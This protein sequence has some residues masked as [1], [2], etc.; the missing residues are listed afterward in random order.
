[1]IKSGIFPVV[2]AFCFFLMIPLSEAGTDDAP[3][4]WSIGA[5]IGP[6]FYTQDAAVLVANQL[7]GKIG[8]I[9]NG[10]FLYKMNRYLGA[11]F[12]L[13]W[14]K[15]NLDSATQ[16]WGEASTFSV[17]LLLEYYLSDKKPFYPYLLAGAGYNFNFFEESGYV[18]EQFP[19][20]K[21]DLDNAFGFKVGVGADLFLLS[22]NLA[23]N[24]E[25]FWKYNR[26]NIT[27]QDGNNVYPDE[28]KG[29]SLDILLGVRYYVPTGPFD[30]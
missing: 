23:I 25:F 7:E 24:I 21:A 28:Y 17:M 12:D 11:G 3:G 15:H 6:S 27:F 19:G 22:D 4:Q 10:V 14:E 2:F 30:W 1:M 8:P 20:L 5:R 18:K 13:E 29:H 26:A 9:I 16:N